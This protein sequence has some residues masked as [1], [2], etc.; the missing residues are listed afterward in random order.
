VTGVTANSVSL[1]WNA[2]TSNVGVT[3]YTIYRN[4]TAVGT[5]GGAN[6]TTYTDLTAAPSTTYSYTVDAF[7]GSGNH[8]PQSSAVQATTSA[9]GAVKVVQA[10]AVSTPGRVTSATIP[11]SG[12]VHTGDLLVGWFAQYD[13]S[14]PVQ[15][16]DNVNGAWTRAGASTTF[17]SGSGDIALYYVQ[18]SAAAPFGLSVTVSA[19]SPTYLEAA[20]SDYVGVATTGALDQAVAAKGNSTSVDSG[21]TPAVG[22]GELVVGGIVTGGGPG[23]VTPGSSQGVNFTMVTQN[24][25][26]SADLENILQSVAGTQDATATFSSATDWYTVVAVFHPAG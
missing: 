18:D 23:T 2:S 24:S 9:A 26:G 21:P 22:A 8:S 12:V 25:S 13:S 15:V 10:G 4:G 3:G 6:A 1:S 7:D 5:T 19:S 11:L 16:S 17:S 14:G 20:A